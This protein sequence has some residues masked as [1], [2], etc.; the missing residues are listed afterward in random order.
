MSLPNPPTTAQAIEG[1]IAVRG[2]LAKTPNFSLAYGV[3]GA[4]TVLDYARSLA[5]PDTPPAIL[6]NGAQSDD[7]GVLACDQA[8]E[9]LQVQDGEV[10][11]AAVAIPWNI[12]VP[13]VLDILKK[14]FLG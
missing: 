14:F 9:S 10:A 13:I 11:A 5:L 4:I 7:A 8:I 12:I 6:T 3:H 1:F 2:Y